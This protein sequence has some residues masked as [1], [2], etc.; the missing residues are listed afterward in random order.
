MQHKPSLRSS[1]HLRNAR[2]QCVRRLR[3]QPLKLRVV[4][5]GAT[6]NTV[7]NLCNEAIKGSSG[8]HCCNQAAIE[9]RLV[10]PS[11]LHASV[12]AGTTDVSSEASKEATP[13]TV[14]PTF[15]ESSNS[16]S[17]NRSNRAIKRPSRFL[18]VEDTMSKS[19]SIPKTSSN[20]T[21]A[22]IK[23]WDNAKSNK[24]EYKNRLYLC[25]TAERAK[26]VLQELNWKKEKEELC[27]V[28]TDQKFQ[29]ENSEAAMEK[30]KSDHKEEIESSAVAMVEVQKKLKSS[31]SLCDYYRAKHDSNE[32]KALAGSDVSASLENT[33]SKLL[34]R[35]HPSTKAK[36]LFD[37]IISGRLYNGAVLSLLNDY[38]KDFIRQKFAPW[39]LLKAGDVSAIGAFKTSTIQALNEVIDEDKL[40]L[41]PSPSAVDRARAKLDAYAFEKIGY[42]RRVT[43]YGEVF[44][45][46]F[47]KALRLLLKACKLHDLATRERVKISLSIDGADLFRDR[48]HVS[49]GVKITD[50]NGIH[51]VTKQPLFIR[52]EDGREEIVRIQ[53][54]QMCCILIIADARDKKDMYEEVFREFYEWG[55]LIS[56]EGLPADGDEPALLPFIVT[57]T[58]DLKAQWYLSNRGGGCKNKNFFCTFC[59]CTRQSLISYN[60]GDQRC[61]RCKR[62]GKRKCYHHAVCDSVSIA[63]L[64]NSLEQELGE[65][66]ARHRRTYEKV[67]ENTKLRTDHMQLDKESDIMHIEYKIPMDSEEKIRE[68]TQFI[69]RECMIR[70]IPLNGRLEDWRQSLLECIQL[71]RSIS[72]LDN[73]KKWYDQGLETVPLVYVVEVLIPCILH[74]ENRVGEKIL[75]M[76]LRAQLD[77]YVGQ[78][79]DFINHMERIFQ[80]EVLGSQLSPSHWT[81]K[82][83]KDTAGQVQ[84]EPIQVRNQVV[85]KM[86]EKIDVIVENAVPQAEAEFQGKLILAVSSYKEAMHLLT[87]H[88]NLSEEERE[89]FQDKIDVFYETWIELFGEEGMTNY[90]HILGSGHMLY[91]LEKYGCLYVYSQQGWEDLN[92]RCQ[93]FLMQNSSRGG[94]GSGEGKGK[95]YTFPIVRYILRD[96]L[97][98]TGLADQFFNAQL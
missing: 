21:I 68:Y 44:Y 77:R 60:V 91:F 6:E 29:F 33:M 4:C 26:S 42:E 98:K 24:A 66:H 1:R 48:T 23:R 3:G 2:M 55:D 54:S 59:P 5:E 35:R 38:M 71:E 85:R 72:M 82:R 51:P 25:L 47:Q 88:R 93:A 62:K 67:R 69:S 27:R 89:L 22:A 50:P 41:F 87:A 28:I 78:K 13:S 43:P 32:K 37:E 92:N 61:N 84:L 30:L 49:A 58:T 97:W 12:S 39:R 80:Q 10:T 57:H 94:Y 95:S 63:S 86:L 36:V 34:P 56:R 8:V 19:N 40:G 52:E 74:C 53:S 11:H 14:P 70:S 83:S 76:I 46:N 31:Q 45:L 18:D 90:I 20:Y 7:V 65:Y 9:G 17:F 15:S 96:L 64:L 73:L 75:T 81:L 79:E 16:S